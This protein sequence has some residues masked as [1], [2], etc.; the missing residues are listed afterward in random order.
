MTDLSAAIKTLTEHGLVIQPPAQQR[1]RLV[2]TAELAELWNISHAKAREIIHSLPNS[3]RI[4]GGDLRA[5]PLD[6][7]KYMEE[8]K[9]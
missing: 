4:G 2:S 9:P 6:L 8:H 3:V 7:E 5:R 1:L